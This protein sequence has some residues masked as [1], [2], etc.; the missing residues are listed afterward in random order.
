[1]FGSAVRVGCVLLLLL[2]IAATGLE[3]EEGS[4]AQSLV[5][6]Y[7]VTIGNGSFSLDCGPQCERKVVSTNI[8]CLDIMF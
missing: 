5:R 1:M 4:A 8:I 2:G 6:I 3:I 7:N